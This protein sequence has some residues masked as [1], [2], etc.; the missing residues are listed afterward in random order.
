MTSTENEF[1]S[2]ENKLQPV[3]NPFNSDDKDF[4]NA[5]A[6]LLQASSVSGMNL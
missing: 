4:V 1:E 6:F 5:K 2:A 3:V